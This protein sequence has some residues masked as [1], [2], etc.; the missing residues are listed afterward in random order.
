LDGLDGFDIEGLS[1][2]GLEDASSS[3]AAGKTSCYH[4]DWNVTFSLPNLSFPLS[5]IWPKIK[6]PFSSKIVVVFAEEIKSGSL[7]SCGQCNCL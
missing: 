5:F 4:N 7:Q 6:S 2:D 1:D 3:Q